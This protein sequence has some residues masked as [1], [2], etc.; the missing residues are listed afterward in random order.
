MTR[1]ALTGARLNEASDS[2]SV[3][4]ISQ[5]PVKKW[6]RWWLAGSERLNPIFI[7]EVRQA[8]K[9]RQFEVSFGLTLIVA[10]GWTF[11]FT[12]MSIPRV[13]Y[14]PSGSILLSG[15][16]S[17]LMVPLLIVIP[18]SAFR[19]LT[20]EIEESTYELLSIST[21]SARQIVTGKMAT[22]ALQILLYTSALAPCIVLTY[23]MRG[24][25]LVATLLLLSCVIA[26]SVMLVSGALMAATVSRSRTG[27]SGMSVVLLSVLVISFFAALNIVFQERVF[28]DLVRNVPERALY[29]G[30]FASVTILVS[31]FSLLMQTAA[32]SIEF[33]SENKS[34]PIRKRLLVLVGVLVFWF[35]YAIAANENLDEEA[36][37]V[38]S[39]MFFLA[40]MFIGGCVCG[41][42]G[43][44]APRTRRSL[45]ATFLGRVLFTWFM[46]GAGL[47]Y[48]Y[49]VL[50]LI[51]V[52]ATLRIVAG[53]HFS[54]SRI[55]TSNIDGA[56]FMMI[57][58]FVFYIG[59][60]R[61]CMLGVSRQVPNRMVVSLSLL[62][63]ILLAFQLGPYFLAVYWNDF[64]NI[65]YDWTQ[66]L[67]VFMT[68]GAI[69]RGGWQPYFLNLAVLTL[70]S[71][72]VFGL[73][74]VLSTKDIM[75]L[76]QAAPERVQQELS[77]KPAVEATK[78]D[79]FQI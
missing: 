14:V 77:P 34:T 24:I 26:Y 51:S 64:A 63:V 16:V 32:A 70:A 59:I 57:V 79:P 1:I 47:G 56:A 44:I 61:L 27:Q 20:S 55:N 48:V 31:M 18:F 21:L 13:Y 45:P 4:R 73:N 6:E 9:S 75:I 23:L 38:F 36:V 69:L 25:S 33:A 39:T 12:A 7:K 11:L 5:D 2:D 17:I 72:L 49:L 62:I 76:R 71:F 53:P 78:I 10:I 50:I 28:S 29:V 67:N 74:L 35:S 52:L 43:I 68:I 22:A 66:T 65:S 42:L 40:W 3:H 46:P 30:V 60:T 58:Y 8:L 41:E 19:S 15:Y 37:I 54:V